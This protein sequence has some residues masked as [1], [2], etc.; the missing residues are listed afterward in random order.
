MS[1]SGYDAFFVDDA[2]NP[3]FS[4]DGYDH[5][6]PSQRFDAYSAFSDESKDPIE[7]DDRSPAF[8]PRPASSFGEDEFPDHQA[9]DFSTF[10]PVSDAIGNSFGD[11]PDLGGS[12]D[13]SNGSI[14]PPPAEMQPEEGFILR[15]WRRQNAMLLQEKENKE[16]ELLNQIVDEADDYKA[17]FYRRK[18]IN[19]EISKANN[20]E[21]EKLFLA[22]QEKFHATADKNYWKAIAELIPQEIPNIEKRR[23]KKEQEKKPSI[24]VIQG[25]K[26]GKPT[27]L[28]RMRQILVKLKHNVPKRRRTLNARDEEEPRLFTRITICYR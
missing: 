27:D 6:G 1:S 14:L 18:E 13:V 19:R 2:M 22:N 7:P 24:T 10:S 12:N 4:E 16:K 25:P 5:R 26:P 8:G 17:D 11:A 23:G 28:S 15:E 20:R 9:P 3:S 21:K